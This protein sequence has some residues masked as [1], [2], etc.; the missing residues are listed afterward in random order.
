MLRS[1][2][3][4]AILPLSIL[5]R[6]D[7]PRPAPRTDLYGDPLPPGAIAR[8]G[9]VELRHPV[10]GGPT[11]VCSPDGKYLASGGIT[12]TTRVWNLATGKLVWQTTP[13][14]SYSVPQFFS[15]D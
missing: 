11:V 13:K 14:Q 3:L 6:T 5:G 12:S 1:M 10:S 8:M 2:I 7:P 9:T 15:Q 4:L